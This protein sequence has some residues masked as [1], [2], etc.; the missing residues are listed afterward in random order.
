MRRDKG[1]SSSSIHSIGDVLG[2]N[3]EAL[4]ADGIAVMADDLDLALVNVADGRVG[5]GVT[6]DNDGAD[7]AHGRSE[8]VGGIV[9]SVAALRVARQDNLGVG[10]CGERA[11]DE[12]GPMTLVLVS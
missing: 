5:H 2:K 7:L 1:S 6:K 9:N 8:V 3:N 10:A 11:L 4:V 12:V